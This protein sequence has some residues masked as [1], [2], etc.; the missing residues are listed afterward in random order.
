[1]TPAFTKVTSI[2]TTE[3]ALLESFSKEGSIERQER[4]K[5]KNASKQVSRLT[6]A[7]QKSMQS[8]TESNSTDY[9]ISHAKEL[10]RPDRTLAGDSMEEGIGMLELSNES[11]RTSEEQQD[12]DNM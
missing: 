7:A 10:L 2:E 1:M 4:F 11:L 12:D 6:L 8:D 9:G 5:A 3:S